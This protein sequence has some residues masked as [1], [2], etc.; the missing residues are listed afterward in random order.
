MISPTNG[1]YLLC[2][3]IFLSSSW[4]CWAQA[5]T[6]GPVLGLLQW[7]SHFPP[8]PGSQ[9]PSTFLGL[10]GLWGSLEGND[11]KRRGGPSSGVYADWPNPNRALREPLSTQLFP[12]SRHCPHPRS[13]LSALTSPRGCPAP[14]PCQGHMHSPG[15]VGAFAS[16]AGPPLAPLD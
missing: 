2:G 8:T 9:A 4:L 3:R 6:G 16:V 1:P 11:R 14:R 13:T 12:S 15:H 5:S 7:V 10:L